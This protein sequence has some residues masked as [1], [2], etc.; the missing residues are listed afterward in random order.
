[1]TYLIQLGLL[2]GEREGEAQWKLLLLYVQLL[3]KV[4]QTIYNVVE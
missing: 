1:M 3:H 4:S 2:T